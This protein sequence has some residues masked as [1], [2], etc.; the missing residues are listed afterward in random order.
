MESFNQDVVEIRAFSLLSEQIAR[1]GIILS[2][3]NVD[4]WD[5]TYLRIR[6]FSWYLM[7]VLIL[8]LKYRG[9]VRSV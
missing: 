9:G 1:S 4:A 8:H 6:L 3:L 7:I 2:I 5:D